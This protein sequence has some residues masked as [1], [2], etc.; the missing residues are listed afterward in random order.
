[1]SGKARMVGT[2]SESLI[3]RLT[4]EEAEKVREIAAR[5][6]KTVSEWISEQI[7]DAPNKDA[8]NIWRTAQA[9]E[10]L[11]SMEA[12]RMFPVD[13]NLKV[14]PSDESVKKAEADYLREKIRDNQPAKARKP[15]KKAKRKGKAA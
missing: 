3:V 1:M 14:V 8:A 9:H 12:N 6:G 11:A 13:S 15:A 7:Y 5:K 4:T 10:I 2:R